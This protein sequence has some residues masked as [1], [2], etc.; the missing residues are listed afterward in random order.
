MKKKYHLLTSLLFVCF[1]YSNAQVSEGY[2][3]NIS[4]YLEVNIDVEDVRG[5]LQD[6]P[7]KGLVSDMRSSTVIINL[8]VPTGGTQQFRVVEAPMMSPELSAQMPDFKS[9]VAQGID[10]TTASARFNITP[11]GFYG[12][13]KGIN[14]IS[15]IEQVDKTSRDNRYITYYDHDITSTN[16]NIFCES[17]Q[18]IDE[19]NMSQQGSRTNSCFQN[20]ASLRSYDMIVTCSGEFYALNGGT[21]GTVQ[22]ALLAR[23]AQINAIYEPELAVTFSIVEYLLNS[24]PATD[25]FTDPTNTSTSISQANTYI[26]SNAS[27]PFDIGH[28]FHEITCGGGCGWAGRAGVGVVCTAS[29]ANGYT[30][31][32][33]DIPTSVTVLL[34]EIGHMFS[35]YH[36]NYGCDSEN[37]CERYEPGQGTSIMST[38]ANCDAGDLFASRTD[39]FGIGSLQSMMNFT[40]T[41]TVPFGDPSCSSGVSGGWTDCSTSTASGN[42]MPSANANANTINGL[43]IPHSTPFTLS[44]TGSDADGLGSLTYN[45]EQYDTDYA[46]SAAPDDTGASTVAPIFRSFPPSMSNE[47]TCPQLSS[48]LAGNVTTGTGEILPT[49]ARTLTWRLVVRDNNAGAGGIACDQISLNV[50]ADGPFQIT[51]QNTTSAWLVGSAQTVTW[52]VAN[53]NLAAYTCASVDILYSSDGG[54]TFGTTLVMGVANDGSQAITVP[55]VATTMGRIKI[56]CSGATNIFFDI[57]NVDI[58]VVAGCTAEA[59]T[60]ANSAGVTAPEGDPS[61]NLNLVAGNLITMNAGTLDAGDPDTGLNI[62]SATAGVCAY[63]GG[64]V[65][66][67]ESIEFVVSDNTGYTFTHVGNGYTDVLNLFQTSYTPFGACT[68]W[69]NSSYTDGVGSSPSFT[70]TLV[71]GITYVLVS[72]GFSAANTLGTYT[73]TF[74]GTGSIYNKAG[75]PGIGYIYT[76]AIVN[77]GTGNIVAFDVNSDLTDS[78]TFPAGSYA[79]HGLSY[80]AG[81]SLATYI[82]NP[83]TTLQTDIGNSTLCGDL[84]TNSVAVT[85]TAVACSTATWTGT[86]DIAPAVPGSNNS[87]II[88]SNYDSSVVGASIDACTVVV[89]AGVALTISA[90]DYLKVKGDITVAAMGSLVV[91]HQGSVVQVND[92]ASVTNNGTISVRVDTPALD[93]LDFMLLGS[94][95][96]LETRADVFTGATVVRNHLTG[97]FSPNAAVALTSPGA[98]N[99]LDEEGDD[100][101]VHTGAINP[102][103]GYFVFRDFVG[104]STVLNLNYNTGTLNNGV[105]TYTAGYNVTGGSAADDQNAS[106]NVIANPYASAISADDFIN[107]NANVGAVYFWEHITAPTAGT[108]G[109]Y[110]LDYTMEDISIYNLTGGTAAGNGPATT[111]NGVISTGQGF[112][113]KVTSLGAI[114][115]NNA[116]RRTSGN[117][118]LRNQDLDRIWL[119]VKSADYDLNSTALIGFMEEATNAIDI[120]YDTK[121]LATNVSLYSHLVDGSDQLAI[122]ARSAFDENVKIPMGFATLIDET[123]EYKVSIQNIEGLNLGDQTAYLVDNQLNTVT[124]LNETNYTFVSEKGIFDNRFT[125]QFTRDGALGIND[126]NLDSVA[127]YPNPAQNIVTI[128]SPQTRVTSATV[129]DIRGRKVSEVDFRNQTTYQIDLTKLESALYFIDIATENGTVMKRVMKK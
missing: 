59:G 97:N 31:L 112:G 61:L 82:G 85:I 68:N 122:Q 96:S 86:W 6:A 93:G 62:E 32:P 102:G 70:Q 57:N 72:S 39:Y 95:M 118:T 71:P 17:D 120:G 121:R 106:P 28:G 35:S 103:E 92:A 24:N 65:P 13:I 43:T 46:G 94:P 78:W 105:I 42:A 23:V 64:N 37:S 30:Y 58:A 10:D 45:W 56:V 125:L 1:M 9:Y 108:P 115:F 91:N 84:S 53:T 14:G 88:A 19:T 52:D 99:W 89:N 4:N 29:K 128:V 15:I 50:G 63:F 20:G 3:Q 7:L 126:S 113:V 83:L 74:T 114:T 124:N 60:I 116:M 66:K 8:P 67:Y 22:A 119:N 110:G 36:T 127:L 104:P 48:V 117:T 107:G 98:G 109:P 100:W 79:V 75:V 51:S 16:Q 80:L 41:G 55:G 76:Y 25:P 18:R 5:V 54:T 73:N 49:V 77:T 12:L 26:T 90:G 111:P 123:I 40:A 101:P 11:I 21:I 2:Q 69:L 47:R 129:F 87:V 44:G 27:V 38:G 34:H 81:S 33:N